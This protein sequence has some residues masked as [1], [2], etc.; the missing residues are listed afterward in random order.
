MSR[1]T[2]QKP[3]PKWEHSRDRKG[4]RRKP[5]LVLVGLGLTV[6]AVYWT[7]RAL[8]QNEQ[9][10][11]STPQEPAARQVESI[12]PFSESEEAAR[13][14]PATLSP[15][16]FSDPRIARAY[17]VAGE[18]PEVLAQQPCYCYCDKFGHRGLLDCYRD[19]HGA[20]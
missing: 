10:A 12:P 14:L 16:S 6:A 3:P 9:A 19:N 18:I 17:R 5:V 2:K 1:K 8:E 20:G 4:P 7:S 11:V 15:A 13:P